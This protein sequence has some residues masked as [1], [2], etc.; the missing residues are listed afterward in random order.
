MQDWDN[1][2]FLENLSGFETDCAMLDRSSWDFHKSK[3]MAEKH[4]KV[5]VGD[6]GYTVN[7]DS[8][9]DALRAIMRGM[10]TVGVKMR[11]GKV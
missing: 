3:Q 9:P 11:N 5:V 4:G 10:K 7:R 6:F 2:H 1:S 8:T